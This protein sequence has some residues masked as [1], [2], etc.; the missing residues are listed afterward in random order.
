M[1]G[2]DGT[3]I[4]CTIADNRADYRGGGVDG[5]SPGLLLRN[6]IV[7]NNAPDEIWC[8]ESCLDVS[9]SNIGGGWPGAGNIGTVPGMRAYRGYSYVLQRGSPCIDAGARGDKDSIRWPSRYRNGV[10]AEMG[11]YGGAGGVGWRK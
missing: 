4:N 5:S 2:F 8:G 3:V 9:Y 1:A 6:C 10:R 7:W 11:A